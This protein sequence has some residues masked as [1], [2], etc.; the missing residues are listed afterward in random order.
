MKH[1]LRSQNVIQ[2]GSPRGACRQVL[3]FERAA[4][5]AAEAERTTPAG[6]APG[7]QSL[8]TSVSRA[9]GM[10]LTKALSKELAQHPSSVV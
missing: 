8:P 10:A 1:V 2:L 4:S 5:C 7:A 3:R 9:A 6:K